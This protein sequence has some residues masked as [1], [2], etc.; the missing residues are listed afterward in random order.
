MGGIHRMIRIRHG[1]HVKYFKKV[2]THRPENLERSRLQ[3]HDR[4][5]TQA[6]VRE[7]VR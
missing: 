7:L 3:T 6:W 4:E 2:K 5:C 1:N